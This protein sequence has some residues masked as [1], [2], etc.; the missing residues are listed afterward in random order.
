MGF[1]A[2]ATAGGRLVWTEE[3]VRLMAAAE[4]KAEQ[5]KLAAKGSSATKGTH[6]SL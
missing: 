1:A 6:V 4:A 3:F 2:G 5:R